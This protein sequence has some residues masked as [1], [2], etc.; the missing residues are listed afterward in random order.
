MPVAAG[1]VYSAVNWSVGMWVRPGGVISDW[2]AYDWWK[3]ET[4]AQPG[5][6]SA[7]NITENSGKNLQP[8][9]VTGI[10]SDP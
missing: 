2:W 7:D 5:P 8:F 3:M 1:L 4:L 6:A 9:S 10:F